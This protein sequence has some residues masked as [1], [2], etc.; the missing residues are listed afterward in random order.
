M[1]QQPQLRRYISHSETVA[2]LLDWF[3]ISL[4][5]SRAWVE[6]GSNTLNKFF[7]AVWF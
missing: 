4:Q 2:N 1:L 7:H 5:K 3:G 6:T